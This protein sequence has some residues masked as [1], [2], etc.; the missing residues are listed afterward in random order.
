MDEFNVR[1]VQKFVNVGIGIIPRIFHARLRVDGRDN[2]FVQTIGL[3]LV[4]YCRA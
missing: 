2:I 3:F 1:S 4:G